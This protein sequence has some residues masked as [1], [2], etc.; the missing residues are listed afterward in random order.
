MV[1][2]LAVYVVAQVLYRVAMMTMAI[3]VAL[4]VTALIAPLTS[5]LKRIR[6]PASLAAFSGV[7][8]LLAVLATASY[9]IGRRAAGQLDDLQAQVIQGADRLRQTLVDTVP[10]LDRAQVDDI[11]ARMVQGL[12]HALP[13]PYSG[14]TTATETLAAV[15]LAIVLLFF[16]LRDGDRMWRW[17]TGLLPASRRSD[18]D[19]AGHSAWQALTSY[20]HGIVAVAAVD[21]VGIGAALF[22]L[23]VPLAMSLA[24]LTFLAAFVPVIGATVAG[25]AA[26]LVTLVTNGTSDAVIVLVVVIIVQQAEGNLL[27]PV[28]MRRAVR[29]HPV[30]TLLAVTAGTLLAGIAGA[31]IAVPACAVVY[32]AILGYRT[33]DLDASRQPAAAVSGDHA[34]PEAEPGVGPAR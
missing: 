3:I 14:V 1:L 33:A 7:A 18:I 5:W 16:F 4:L 21:A 31:L 30:V 2:A 23:D 32:H 27:H 22:L 25:A 34:H 20:T 17:L 15:L 26:T 9:L 28:I 10:G 29:L 11:A 24:V 6:V 8:G 13:S 12:R 19:R